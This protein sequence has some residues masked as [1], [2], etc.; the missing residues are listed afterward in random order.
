MT[1]GMSCASLTLNCYCSVLQCYSGASAQ[2]LDLRHHLSWLT[3]DC[4]LEAGP[5]FTLPLKVAT[6]WFWS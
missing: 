6:G 5:D 2:Y 1:G 4:D 3:K